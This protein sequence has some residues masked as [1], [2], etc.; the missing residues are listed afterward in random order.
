[1]SGPDPFRSELDAA[2]RRIETLEAEHAARV[3]ELERENARLRGRL[4][5]VAPSRNATGRTFGA[6]GMIILGV[7]L[8]G[9]MFFARMTRSPS[10]VP[11]APLEAVELPIETDEP[12]INT[13]RTSTGDFDR[14]GVAFALSHVHIEDC[15]RPDD[16]H[17]SGHAKLT[18]APIGIITSAVV[19][20]GSY[21]GTSTG[22]C[23]EDRFR[24]ARV[25]AFNGA[26]R[27][28]GKSFV[29]P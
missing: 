1:M 29:I 2:H 3:S 18:I 27:M 28:V 10:P 17:L 11:I 5:D 25:P 12:T 19:D 15:V 13:D 24:A 16:P 22:H 9:G 8:A 4:I 21:R 7:S 23:I 26:S 6:L 14:G 20:G